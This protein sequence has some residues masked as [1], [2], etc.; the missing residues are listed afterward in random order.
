MI[1]HTLDYSFG[2]PLGTSW[3]SPIKKLDVVV[4]ANRY[5]SVMD[6][7][8][9]LSTTSGCRCLMSTAIKI[10]PF[11]QLTNE[12]VIEQKTT[13]CGQSFSRKEIWV[14]HEGS[15]LKGSVEMQ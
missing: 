3:Y 14:G 11:S 12:Q 4:E 2:T 5:E 1:A 15:Q 6:E 10:S 13:N 7:A 9:F 8:R